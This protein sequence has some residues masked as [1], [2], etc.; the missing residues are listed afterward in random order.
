MNEVGTNVVLPP[1][2]VDV[3]ISLGCKYLLP[4]GTILGPGT[5]L[6]TSLICKS[7]PFVPDAGFVLKYSNISPVSYTHLTLPTK[8]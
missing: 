4:P 7:T 3:L 2:S 6:I 8:A 5:P 1:L